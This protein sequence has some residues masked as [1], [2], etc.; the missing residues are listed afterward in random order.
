MKHECDR[1]NQTIEGI[2]KQF[3]HYKNIAPPIELLSG[4]MYLTFT[5]DKPHG[6]KMKQ[7]DVAMLLSRCPLC[8]EKYEGGDE[9][10]R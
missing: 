3:P 5:A 7:V 2:K 9:D 10:G 6:I 1:L 4:K 8:G